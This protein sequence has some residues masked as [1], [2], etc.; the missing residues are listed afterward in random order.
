MRPPIDLPVL[1]FVHAEVAAALHAAAFVPRQERPWT[2]GELGDLIVLP[3][4]FGHLAVDAT[5]Q[6]LGFILCRVAGDQAELLTL[7]VDPAHQGR[8]LGRRLVAAG[9]AEAARLGAG[10]MVL[11]V[12]ED[13]QPALYLYH[14]LGFA[15]LGRRRRYY[16]RPA[17]AVDALVLAL[18]LV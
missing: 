15:P 12:A 5:G 6:P 13:N 18:R 8:G 1:A 9:L 17:G 3:G 2:P 7:A 14:A 16:Q 10:E 4:S 11:E